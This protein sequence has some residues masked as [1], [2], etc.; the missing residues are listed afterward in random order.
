MSQTGT[1]SL[2]KTVTVHDAAVE[3][4]RI[5]CEAKVDA[6]LRVKAV[7]ALLLVLREGVLSDP[8]RIG[9]PQLNQRVAQAIGR[10]P[11]APAVRQKLRNVLRL[12]ANF[13][14]MLP[15]LGRIASLLSNWTGHPASGGAD[16]FSVFYEAFLHYGYDN[17][18]LGIVFT[19]R[20]IA[21]FCAELAGVT[22]QDRVIDVACGTGSFL[23]AARAQAR[24][25]EQPV[26]SGRAAGQPISTAKITGPMLAGFDTNP[27]VWALALL[28]TVAA[29]TAPAEIRPGNCLDAANRGA[30]RRRFTRAFLN[31]PFSQGSEPERNFIDAS[32]E[33]LAPGGRCTVLV[34]A[35]I[36]AD[37]EHAA[38]R[39]T[40]L[41]H[42]SVL[43]VIAVPDDVFYPTSAPA[44]ILL[45]EAHTPQRPQALV[46][47]A[48]VVNDGFEKLKNRRVERIGCELPEVAHCFAATFAGRTF[49]SNLAATIT[50]VQ[51]QN[52]A[53]WSPH[54]WLPQSHMDGVA[55]AA[56][57]KS[58]LAAM[59]GAVADRPELSETVLAGF[60]NQWQ[61]L[62]PLPLGRSA[63]LG[64]FFEIANGRS[65]GERHYP[66]GAIAYVSSSGLTNSIVRLV[67][68]PPED[69]FNCG[70]ITVTAFGQ[71]GVQPWPFVA[72]G[73]GGSAVRILRPRF[74][75]GESELLWFAAQINA[76]RWRFFYARMAIKSRIERL[77]V[78]SPPHTL[79][80]LGRSLAERA[81]AM[82]ARLAELCDL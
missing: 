64:D 33:A 22:A 16:A 48:R 44:A 42:H 70:G 46:M 65:A 74:A 57:Q 75:M 20:H 27:T 21:H 78:S 23:V 14:G 35:G 67:D 39:A 72:R 17:N 28:N 54:E 58:V 38:W 66:A 3:I 63:A 24:Q 45:A 12:D 19:P 69:V 36:F 1:A 10:L 7:A 53:E 32:M 6:P 31:P 50:G 11:F 29:D 37:E 60:G 47:M 82:Q 9:L 2:P 59:L 13:S 43:A 61:Q 76:Q 41:R 5:L 25:V 34:K 40:F 80:P 26:A 55:V 52:G 8:P 49:V 18:A 56:E 51:L 71:T 77:V 73:N 79:A 81:R 15:H 4:S 62:P 30:V 68:A